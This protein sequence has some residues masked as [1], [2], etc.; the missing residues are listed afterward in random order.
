MMDFSPINSHNQQNE[1]YHHKTVFPPRTET[2]IHTIKS[3]PKVRAI[4]TTKQ[5]L[6]FDYLFQPVDPPQFSSHNNQGILNLYIFYYLY[7]IKKILMF[8]LIFFCLGICVKVIEYVLEIEKRRLTDQASENTQGANFS[9]ETPNFY[10][11]DSMNN[12]IYLPSELSIQYSPITK[13]SVVV[14][15]HNGK[16]K[17]CI[18]SVP[19]SELTPYNQFMYEKSVQLYNLRKTKEPV[20]ST[21]NTEQNRSPQISNS[22]GQQYFSSF[23]RY[24]PKIPDTQLMNARPLFSRVPNGTADAIGRAGVQSTSPTSS[25]GVR[26]VVGS[27]AMPSVVAAATAAASAAPS[28]GHRAVVVHSPLLCARCVVRCDLSPSGGP[29]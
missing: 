28:T 29:R 15:H 18:P 27:R 16:N 3:T 11:T 13:S 19:T 26:V 6:P 1:E 21:S 10:D 7:F 9:N 22:T 23:A 14:T 4:N 5:I 24:I 25:G 2:V 17:K 12:R 20:E 8:E